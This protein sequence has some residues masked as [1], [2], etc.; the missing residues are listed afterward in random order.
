VPNHPDECEAAIGT[1]DSEVKAAFHPNTQTLTVLPAGSGSIAANSG[2][3]RNCSAQ[4][5]TCAGQYIETATATLTA[6]PGPGQAVAW[7]GC[8]AVPSPN[9]CQV[10]IG[11][12]E[13]AVK[14]TFAPIAHALSVNKAGSG[15]GSVTCDG[16]PCASS[17]P[18]GTAL[19]L[20][21][22]PAAGSTFAGWSGG[23]C[24]GTGA[25]KITLAADTAL[26][27]TFNAKP[28]PPAEE[29][30]VVPSLVGDTLGQGRTALT[31]AHCSL[32]T[33]TKPKR[34]KGHKLGPLVVR[35]SSPS[36]GTALPVDAKV[37]LTL[38]PKPKK[39]KH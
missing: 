27:A 12:S 38:T 6:A 19:T 14:A 32:G 18:E 36:A 20:T 35:S 13:T 8:T 4:G 7:Q 23:G 21:A 3:I 11:P 26:T 31:A 29:K 16:T 33:V 1:A 10:E 2:P 22:S 28:S 17:Y 39:R 30:C 34:K 15:Q 9:R 25:C 24:S 37:D 5:G